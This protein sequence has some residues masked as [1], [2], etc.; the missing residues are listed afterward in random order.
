MESRL[1]GHRKEHI[2]ASVPSRL[3]IEQ[4]D[5]VTV[6]TF[7]D[8]RLL[9]EATIDLVGNQ[10]YSLVDDHGFDKVVLDFN[11]VEYMSSSA[12][13]K[14]IKVGGLYL[15][16][17]AADIGVA[18]VIDHDED[19]VGPGPVRFRASGECAEHKAGEEWGN[20]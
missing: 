5:G 13:G 15:A 18:H 12:L 14:L 10:L 8:R 4:A 20:G 19:D 7:K 16:A 1:L 6:A 2:M 17:I 11:D 9:D 3:D